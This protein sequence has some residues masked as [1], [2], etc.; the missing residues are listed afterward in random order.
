M[1]KQEQLITSVFAG[2]RVTMRSGPG[3][4]T[5]EHILADVRDGCD[6]LYLACHGT[7]I[8]DRPH[9]YLVNSND[10]ADITDGRTFV[11]RVTSLMALPPRLVV[12]AS[13]QSGGGG[14]LSDRADNGFLAAVGPRCLDSG[15]P[16]VVGMQ[17]MIN[18]DTAA[19]FCRAFFNEL[20]K[21]GQIEQAVAVARQEIGALP[22]A[23]VP[24]LLLSL[25]SGRLWSRERAAPDFPAWD[26]LIQRIVER[27][28][29]PI[30][31]SELLGRFSNVEFSRFLSTKYQNP[32]AVH[33]RE[34]LPRMAQYVRINEGL[35]SPIDELSLFLRERIREDGVTAAEDESMVNLVSKWGEAFHRSH[36]LDPHDVLARLPCPVYVSANPDNLLADALLRYNREPVV[37]LCPWAGPYDIL[38]DNV[39]SISATVEHPLVYHLFGRLSEPSTVTITEDDFLDHL[40]WVSVNNQKIP[41][42]VK[43]RLCDSAL[44]FLGF[45]LQ[46]WEF[47]ILMRCIAK[48]PGSQR[49]AGHLHVA[50]QIDPSEPQ[51]E[52]RLSVRHQLEQY[53]GKS[54]IKLSIYWGT[55]HEFVAE[56]DRR[57]KMR[58]GPPG[59]QSNV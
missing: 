55:V 28:C 5:M 9:L 58:L 35:S 24:V 26:R 4:A 40:I 6:V 32:F 1:A 51:H 48:L 23:W 47:R 3:E 31:G 33:D 21:D 50:V 44:L 20:L 52:D 22:E 45:R 18:Q 53:F 15:I 37:K 36:A 2:A 41:S 14:Q 13:C 25:Q 57:L 56:L 27:K 17:S 59:P 42:V 29:T 11:E 49:L 30:L 8:E 19:S 34:E 46:D 54:D 43:T 7:L 12:F 38:A 39:G 16:A 10:E